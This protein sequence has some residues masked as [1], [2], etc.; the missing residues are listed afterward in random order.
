MGD[1]SPGQASKAAGAMIIKSNSAPLLQMFQPPPVPR[2]AE[3][4]MVPKHHELGQKQAII[5][6]R[7]LKQEEIQ[8]LDFHGFSG[9]VQGLKAF[10][11]HKYGSAVRGWR[12]DIA[13]DEIGLKPVLFSDFT[14]AM[15]KMGFTGNI[16]SL[17]KALTKKKSESVSL[18]DFDPKTA[19]GL[20]LLAAVLFHAYPGGVQEAWQ[21][22]DKENL[23]RANFREFIYFLDERDLLEIIRERTG[24]SLRRLFDALDMKGM[25]SITREDFRFLDHWAAK[26]HKVPLPP[27]MIVDPRDLPEPAPWSPPPPEKPKEPGIPEFRAFLEHKY[28]GIGGAARAWRTSLDLKGCGAVSISDFGKGCR[29]VGWKHE[30]S[31]MYRFLKEAGDGLCKLRALDPETCNAIDLFKEEAGSRYGD[32]VTLWNELLDPGGTGT[33]SRTEYLNDVC[34]GLGLSKTDARRVFAALDTAGTGWVSLD[35]LSWLEIF[36]T[37]LAASAAEQE[38][39]E[40]QRSTSQAFPYAPPSGEAAPK[41]G[42]RKEDLAAEKKARVMLPPGA[43]GAYNLPWQGASSTK[44]RL[45]ASMASPLGRELW[46]PH[47]S[48]RSFQNRAMANTHQLKHRWLASAAEDRCIYS[49]HEKVM[50]MRTSHLE[51]IKSTSQG[52]IF[53]STNEFYRRGVDKLLQENDE[54][55]VEDDRV[56]REQSG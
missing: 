21:D 5:M 42:S 48:S 46:A 1:H 6:R 47:R 15:R 25:G 40:A 3:S 18:E 10:L 34:S 26:R 27:S 24:A 50:K 53:R 36:E 39:L 32:L 51:Q 37:G 23:W 14:T 55:E 28:G 4:D 8:R 43:L 30:H 13:P 35:E 45:P 29:A 22:I 11:T 49:N 38:V 20:D 52:D 33:T 41:Q 19:Q 9:D 7:K 17:W 54:D 56:E 2:C 12:R 44:G 16:M 31:I